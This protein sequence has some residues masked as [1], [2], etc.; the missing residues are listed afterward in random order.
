MQLSLFDLIDDSWGEP[1]KEIESIPEVDP[2]D[3]GTYSHYSLFDDPERV[4][5]WELF[6]SALPYFPEADRH[7]ISLIM[8]GSSWHDASKIIYGTST[9][10]GPATLKMRLMKHYLRITKLKKALMWKKKGASLSYLANIVGASYKSENRGALAH[11][12]I[13]KWSKFYGIN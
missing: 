2:W 11:N 9:Y 12:Y 4:T 8:G 5:Q 6:S 3:D 10:N 13:A 7:A 1:P